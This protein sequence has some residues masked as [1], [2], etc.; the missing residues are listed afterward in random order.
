MTTA[1][2]RSPRLLQTEMDNL[3]EQ[4]EHAQALCQKLVTR[5]HAIPQAERIYNVDSEY[6]TCLYE[7]MSAH[8][9][10]NQLMAKFIAKAHQYIIH[11]ANK[12]LATKSNAKICYY[13]VISPGHLKLVLNPGNSTPE[14]FATITHTL[15]KTQRIAERTLLNRYPSLITTVNKP[16]IAEPPAKRRAVIGSQE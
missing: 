1:T 15:A 11:K 13:Q 3:H 6:K 9:R 5:L 2:R 7:I 8:A 4:V 10:A 14:Q 12:M 16:E